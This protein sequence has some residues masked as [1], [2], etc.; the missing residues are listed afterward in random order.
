MPLDPNVIKA[1][2][3][4]DRALGAMAS[5]SETPEGF[6]PGPPSAPLRASLYWKL[7]QGFVRLYR[8]AVAGDGSLVCRELDVASGFLPLASERWDAHAPCTPPGPWSRALDEA[9]A[10]VKLAAGEVSSG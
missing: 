6:K 5:A 9:D 3:A 10:L 8:V 2:P 4:V 1:R 7:A